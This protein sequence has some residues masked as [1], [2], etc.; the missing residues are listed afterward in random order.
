MSF[1][2]PLEASI[3]KNQLSS[4]N[5]GL[6]SRISAS[7]TLNIYMFIAWA[8]YMLSIAVDSQSVTVQLL[9]EIYHDLRSCI[10]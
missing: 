1:F 3:S 6:F 9:F 5:A 10:F 8:L 4:V 2:Y 7:F